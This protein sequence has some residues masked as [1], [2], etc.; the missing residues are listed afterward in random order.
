MILMLFLAWEKTTEN[1][2]RVRADSV[3][4]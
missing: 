1:A 3:Q 2:V 4:N